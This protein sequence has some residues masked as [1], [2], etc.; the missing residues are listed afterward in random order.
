[1]RKSIALFLMLALAGTAV[2][3][4]DPHSYAEPERFLVRHV[5]LDLSADFAAHRLEGTAEL[6]VLRID[7]EAKELRLDTRDLEV[8]SVHLIEASGRE[9]VLPFTL[10]ATDPVLGSRLTISFTSCCVVSDTLRLRIGYRTSAEASAL[11]WLDPA[12]TSGPHPYMY[13]QGQAIH[14][15][16]WIPV[17][18]SPAVRLTYTARIR[19]P[20]EL[21]ALAG[22][23]AAARGAAGG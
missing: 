4:R 17:Q 7:P 5:A 23:P 8:R 15:R 18:D 11:Q 14:A 2:A 1:M 9:R 12:Q 13:S 16:S 3:A 20:P 21:T 6:T 10:D 22:P 19:T